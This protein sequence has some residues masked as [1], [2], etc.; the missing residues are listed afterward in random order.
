MRTVARGS[1]G[2]AVSAIGLSCMGMSEFFGPANHDESLATLRRAVEL[3]VSLLDT[4]DMYG[5]GANERLLGEFLARGQRD[6]AIVA[7]K[8]GAV[9]DPVTVPY[10][11][12]GRGFLTGVYSS[13]HG[14]AADDYRQVIPRFAAQK[15]EHNADLLKP[16]Q[17]IAE[18]YGATTGQVAL[19]SLI[20]QSTA[21]GLAVVPI[22][23]TKHQTRLKENAAAV[24]IHLT[25]D[26]LAAVEPIAWARRRRRP[27]RT[28]A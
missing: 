5:I 20:Q 27:S 1:T 24:D 12:L 21:R 15:A 4:A 3:G 6:S 8:F 16:I 25:E 9:R 22:P 11:P 7:T 28:P 19:A 18:A 2:L 14:L 10:S 17:Q 26:D 23:G 13:T